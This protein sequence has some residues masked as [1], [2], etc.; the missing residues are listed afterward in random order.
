MA[1]YSVGDR[2]EVLWEDELFDA[3]VIKLHASGAVDVAYDI[4]D[5]VGVHLTA[6]DDG[7]KLLRQKTSGSRKGRRGEEEGVLSGRLLQQSRRQRAL[8]NTMPEE[9]VLG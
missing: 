1:G 9:T 6:E 8:H 4:N 3:E 2:V 7:L 5:S